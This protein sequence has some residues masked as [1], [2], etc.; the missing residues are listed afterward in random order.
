M[1][2]VQNTGSASRAKTCKSAPSVAKMTTDHESDKQPG[3]GYDEE[4]DES[5][6]ESQDEPQ[7]EQDNQQDELCQEEDE[8]YDG[9]DEDATDGSHDNRYHG[10]GQDE[11]SEAAPI[12]SGLIDRH[13]RG[14]TVV[15]MDEAHA[16]EGNDSITDEDDIDDGQ[17]V[18]GR[19]RIPKI[20][21]GAMKTCVQKSRA[22][23]SI[24]KT[25]Q[26][27]SVASRPSSS[28][29]KGNASK[30]KTKYIVGV[31]DTSEVEAAQDQDEPAKP[32]RGRPPKNRGRGAV[33]R[34]VS[35][36]AAAAATKDGSR[37]TSKVRGR[38]W[39]FLVI[40][41][42]GSLPTFQ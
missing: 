19:S 15:R 25:S 30:T 6:D 14:K 1:P 3:A 34:A 26:S 7:D 23:A 8:G 41:I 18:R 39:L 10:D 32:R 28:N 29:S 9:N 35:R 38:R 33:P 5:Q 13:S 20:A 17:P 11:D 37:R 40:F 16:A 2:S 42:R 36:T 12:T 21:T 4:Q 27:N 31:N 24:D 22:L